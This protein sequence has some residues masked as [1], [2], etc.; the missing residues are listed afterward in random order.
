MTSNLATSELCLF[1][2]KHDPCSITCQR[3]AGQ[4]SLRE[5]RRP[6]C[7]RPRD[8][9]RQ[10]RAA[11]LL[12]PALAPWP[13]VRERKPGLSG[14]PEKLVDAFQVSAMQVPNTTYALRLSR[15]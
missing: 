15:R 11:S 6:Q 2:V 7:G 9:A 8:P 10:L 5:R 13:R 3:T 14:P 12:P 1:H 4:K